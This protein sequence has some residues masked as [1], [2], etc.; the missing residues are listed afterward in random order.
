MW[1]R[2]RARAA[3]LGLGRVEFPGAV[4]YAEA[5]RLFAAVHPYLERERLSPGLDAA[6]VLEDPSAW[7]RWHSGGD[8][9][10]SCSAPSPSP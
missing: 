2:C 7:R 4:P 8:R 9:A 5:P 6:L 1:E 3:E 10:A